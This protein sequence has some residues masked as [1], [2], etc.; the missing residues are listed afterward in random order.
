[1]LGEP[2]NQFSLYPR[3]AQGRA[4]RAKRQILNQLHGFSP[5]SKKSLVSRIYG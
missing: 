2:E 3:S 4:V 5:T 1:M